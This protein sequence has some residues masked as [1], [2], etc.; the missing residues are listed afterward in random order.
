MSCV[1]SGRSNQVEHWIPWCVCRLHSTTVGPVCLR[2]EAIPAAI[3]ACRGFCFVRASLLGVSIDLILSDH[4]TTPGDWR[5]VRDC[6]SVW[7]ASGYE[8]ESRNGEV[9]GGGRAGRRSAQ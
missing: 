9:A 4:T 6:A 5:T 2:Q 1:E 3:L 7:L 8:R